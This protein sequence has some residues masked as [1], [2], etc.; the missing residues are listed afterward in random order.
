MGYEVIKQSGAAAS[1]S[2]LAAMAL[3]VPLIF[4]ARYATHS[5][6]FHRPVIAYDSIEPSPGSTTAGLWAIASRGG[7]ACQGLLDAGGLAGLADTWSASGAPGG[8]SSGTGD[9]CGGGTGSII[10][11]AAAQIGLV[12][13][14]E[15]A[16]ARLLAQPTR[17]APRRAPEQRGDDRLPVALR[18]RARHRRG[19]LPDRGDA[20]QPAIGTAQW[21]E[22]RPAWLGLLTVVLVPMIIVIMWAERPMRRLPVG[23]GPPGSWSPVLLLAG[24]AAS[25]F[26]LSQLTIAGFAPGGH[27]PALALAACAVG[28]AATL[29]SGRD[30]AAGARPRALSPQQPPKAA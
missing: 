27:L 16:A 4:L 29:S 18:A 19:L 1:A 17:V 25:L 22:L 10:A 20:P 13:A 24:L 21:W 23:I 3:G 30:P 7:K 6:F 12:L 26:G 5:D 9:V 2:V 28:L 11:Y 8:C 14:A 15:P